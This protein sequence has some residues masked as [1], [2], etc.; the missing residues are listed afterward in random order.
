MFASDVSPELFE[1]K[2][3]AIVAV[4]EVVVSSSLPKILVASR[5]RLVKKIAATEGGASTAS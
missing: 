1:R 4:D 5:A 3:K 2:V